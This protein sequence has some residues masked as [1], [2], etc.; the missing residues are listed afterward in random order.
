MREHLQK[1]LQMIVTKEMGKLISRQLEMLGSNDAEK[2]KLMPDIGHFIKSISNGFHS[3][4]DKKS[5]F[6]GVSLLDPNRVRS[7]SSDVSRHLKDYHKIDK[8]MK[9]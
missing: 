8:K 4:K 5:E 1:K 2:D 9:T 6:S 3:F 7:T